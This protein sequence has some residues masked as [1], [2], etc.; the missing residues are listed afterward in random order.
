MMGLTQFDLNVPVIKGTNAI[1]CFTKKQKVEVK[2]PHCIRCGRCVGVCPMHL[3]PLYLYQAERKDN[4]NELNRRNISD[5]IEWRLLRLQSSC[6]AS[7]GAELQKRQRRR[8]K[9]AAAK[10]N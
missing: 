1:T 3:M 6:T 4:I 8:I 10:K 5:C 2:T 9:A 7:A